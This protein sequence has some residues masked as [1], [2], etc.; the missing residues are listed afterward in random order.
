M[1]WLYAIALAAGFLMLLVWIVGVA[2]AA[3]VDGWEF[4][5]PDRRFGATGRA[6]IA[7][8]IGFGMAGMSATFAGWHAIVAILAAFVG[9]AALVAVGR[10]F[11]PAET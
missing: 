4:A 6:V 1:V 8:A 7:T 10:V 2:L 11:A 9:A 5:D 3:W